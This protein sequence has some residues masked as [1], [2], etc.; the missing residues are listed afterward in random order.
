[1]NPSDLQGDLLQ[2]GPTMKPPIQLEQLQAQCGF[3]RTL[4]GI[5]L[6]ALILLSFGVLLVIGKQMSAVRAQ[7]DTAAPDAR[8]MIAEFQKQSEP[9][10]RNFV[11]SLQTYAVTHRDFN[12][13]LE[14][15]RNPLYRYFTS[16]TSMPPASVPKTAPK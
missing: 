13:T 2:S 7:L 8:L 4:L 1:M 14:K 15:Y 6:I 11:G 5:M 9:L 3:L 12:Q 10:V 16:A